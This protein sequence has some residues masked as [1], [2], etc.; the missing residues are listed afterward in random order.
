MGTLDPGGPVKSFPVDARCP[1]GGT[2]HKLRRAAHVLTFASALAALT[3]FVV[4]DVVAAETDEAT[5]MELVTDH[6]R[7]FAGM[8]PVLDRL[9]GTHAPTPPPWAADA[10][11]EARDWAKTAP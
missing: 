8:L 6:H 5:A 7:N 1:A 2:M 9:F 4:A 3:G 11:I 10:H